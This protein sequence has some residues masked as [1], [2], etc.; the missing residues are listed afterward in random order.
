MSLRHCSDTNVGLRRSINQDA[1]LADPAVGLFV[2][3]DGMGGHE[4]GEVAADIV[5]TSIAEL[6]RDTATDGDK[7]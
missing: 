2:V 3:A 5:V 7:P 1:L 4:R 6:V